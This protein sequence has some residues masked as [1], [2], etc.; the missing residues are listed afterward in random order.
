M[1]AVMG[2]SGAGAAGGGRLEDKRA[3]ITGAGSGIGAAVAA[4]FARHGAAVAVADRDADAAAR[5]ARA[6]AD[7]GGRA[8]PITADVSVRRAAEACVDDAVAAFGGL[9]VVV[10]SAGVTPRYAPSDWD[11]ERVWDWVMAVNLKGTYLISRRAAQS[12]AGGGAIVNLSSIYGLVGR[13]MFFGTGDDP[14]PP[15]KAGVIGLTRD[16]ANAFGGRGIRVNALCP[17]FVLTPLTRTL[18]GDPA[19]RARMEAM[20]PLGRLGTA[21]EV[22]YAALFLASDEASFITGA[23]LPVDGGYTSV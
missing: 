17:A 3:L 9:D 23:A 7:G 10:N 14:Y 1:I 15:G 20:Q 22:A 6:I 8:V 21:E 12:M 13:P 11:Y 19:W 16:M 5:T 18:T 2:A 4:M